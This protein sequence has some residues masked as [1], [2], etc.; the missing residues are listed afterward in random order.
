M[1]LF[2][3][4]SIRGGITQSTKRYAKANINTIPNIKGLNYNS[5]EPITWITYLDC[6]NLYG[7]S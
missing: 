1:L 4:N 6:V 3:E 2:I 5:N 7:K